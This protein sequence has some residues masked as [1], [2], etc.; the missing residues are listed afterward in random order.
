VVN[1]KIDRGELSYCWF[2]TLI[3]KGHFQLFLP[4]KNSI[5]LVNLI[6]L[7]SVISGR[8]GVFFQGV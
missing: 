5:S 8:L 3:L 4:F 6:L 2:E 7:L 1:D